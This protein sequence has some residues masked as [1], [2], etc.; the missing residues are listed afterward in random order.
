MFLS[1]SGCTARL[2]VPISTSPILAVPATVR[3]PSG[4][5]NNKSPAYSCI[6]L[7]KGSMHPIFLVTGVIAKLLNEE[8]INAY[9]INVSTIKPLKDPLICDIVNECKYFITAENHSMIGGLGDAI[10][11]FLNQNKVQYFHSKVG[12]NDI[13]AEGA[14]TDYLMNKYQMNFESIYKTF[15]E[16]GI[17]LLK[18]LT[19]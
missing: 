11:S 16:Y 7:P 5:K 1:I 10:A 14:S 9:V 6:V 13:F 3:N 12:L 18:T 15:V 2:I 8:G 17:S 19:N 4:P